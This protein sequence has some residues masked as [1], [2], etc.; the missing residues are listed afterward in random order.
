MP[1]LTHWRDSKWFAAG[2][3]RTSARSRGRGGSSQVQPTKEVDA[4]IDD[5]NHMAQRVEELVR[6][7]RHLIANVSH[8][9]R[10]PLAL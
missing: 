6:S 10:S 3:P 5:F 8:E 4:L 7:Q 1:T 9:L 2:N